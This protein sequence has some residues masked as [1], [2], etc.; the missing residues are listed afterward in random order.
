MSRVASSE[1]TV[2]YVRL[3]YYLLQV[4]WCVPTVVDTGFRLRHPRLTKVTRNQRFI[5]YLVMHPTNLP[6][7]S[8][9]SAGRHLQVL[10]AVSWSVE[11]TINVDPTKPLGERVTFIGPARQRDP[12]IID[13]SDA[14]KLTENALHPPN[15][16]SSQMLVWW[17]ADGNEEPVVVVKPVMTTPS[18]VNAIHAYQHSHS[19]HALRLQSLY[20]FSAKC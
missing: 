13:V 8:L 5:T 6:L 18:I 12:E 16:N 14:P 19:R 11:V 3:H 7:N 20:R 10:K 15:A 9:L 17:P 4:T 1:F 2:C